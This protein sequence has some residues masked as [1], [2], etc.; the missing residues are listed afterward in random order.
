MVMRGHIEQIPGKNNNNEAVQEHEKKYLK[1]LYSSSMTCVLFAVVQIS[2][3]S[4]V[5]SRMVTF[6]R[7]W[8]SMTNSC[9]L[10][11][12]TCCMSDIVVNL[13]ETVS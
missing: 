8:R 3:F 13:S 9:E 6:L 1:A 12:L 2:G 10:I 11:Q 7:L 5:F 4:A